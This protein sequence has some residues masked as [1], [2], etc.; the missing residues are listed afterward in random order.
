MPKAPANVPPRNIAASVRARLLNHAR[1][2][3]QP[4][5]LVLGL[6]KL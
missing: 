4:F 2:H 3:D 5:D 6:F 1:T